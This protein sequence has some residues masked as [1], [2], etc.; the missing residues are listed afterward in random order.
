MTVSEVNTYLKAAMDSDPILTDIF[1]RGEIS[2][3]KFHTSGHHYMT[4]KDEAAAISAVLFKFDALRLKFR[5]ENG[6]SV[7][8]HGRISVFPRSG[9]YQLYINEIVPDG[10]GAL[11]LA[12]EQ[13]KERLAKEGLFD[14]ERKKPLPKYPKKIAVVTSPT[15]A[16]VRDI[17]RILNRRFPYTDVVVCPVSVQGES[18]PKEISEMI[19]YVDR[20]DLADII[21]T[22]RGGGSIEDLWAFNDEGVAMAISRAKTPVVS[23][24]GHEP[25]FTIADFVADMRAPTPSAAAEMAVPDVLELRSALAHMSVRMTTVLLGRVSYMRQRISAIA[26]KRI[27]K[28]PAAYVQEKRTE[29]TFYEQRILA[30]IKEKTAL[31]KRNFVKLL[32][33]L[34]AMNPYKVLMRGYSIA[35]SESGDIIR[36]ANDIQNGDILNLK[37]ASGTAKCKVIERGLE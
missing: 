4:L 24:V 1:I 15:G 19:D 3:Y 23:A 16:A 27:F 36:S 32:S 2:N 25:D 18:A 30:A 11:A 6:M 8:A 31:Q 17:I 28:N 5:I 33:S 34:D 13:I 22:G 26:E 10:I 37:F 14:P 12:F 29:V 21:I 35:S 7:I 20:N 9:Q